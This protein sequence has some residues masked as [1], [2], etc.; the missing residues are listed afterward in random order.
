MFGIRKQLATEYYFYKFIYS[1]NQFSLN[2]LFFMSV[3]FKDLQ[4]TIW[5]KTGNTLIQKET[6][7]CDEHYCQPSVNLKTA[8]KKLT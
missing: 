7:L 1:V 5:Q 8:K 4:Q 3:A 6:S 2:V